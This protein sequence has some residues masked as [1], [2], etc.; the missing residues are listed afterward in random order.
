MK[1]FSVAVALLFAATALFA[2]ATGDSLAVSVREGEVRSAPGFLSRI[3]GR[4][5]YGESVTVQE[6]R[7]DWVRVTVA[8]DGSEGWMH[9]TSVLPPGE[10]NLTGSTSGDTGTSSREIALA[11]RGFNEQVE[12]EYK[13]QSELDFG[14]VDEME[15]L[16]VDPAELGDFLGEIGARIDEGGE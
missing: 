16:L 6:V 7:G 10:M 15:E 14:R 12:Q 11:G 4:V 1:R 8:A 3:D 5:A 13:D 2:I 9:T